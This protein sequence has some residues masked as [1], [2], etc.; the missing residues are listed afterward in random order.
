M[1]TMASDNNNLTEQQQLALQ[2]YSS[3]TDQDIETA[4][5]LLRRSQWNVEIAIAKFFDG[6]TLDPTVEAISSQGPSID[7]PR[8]LENLQ[9]TALLNSVLPSVRQPRPDPAPRIVPQLDV[10]EIRKPPFILAIFLAPFNL[11]YKSV[12]SSLSILAYL[13]PLTRFVRLRNSASYQQSLGRRPLKPRDS[14]AR[15]KREFEEEYGPNRLPFYEGGYAQA[16]DLAKAE[17]K[18]LVIVL[19]SPEHDETTKFVRDTLL[20]A[21]IQAYLSDESSNII[22]WAGDV[23]D[24][25]AYQ[26]SAAVKCS[27]FPYTAVVAHTPVISTTSMSVITALSGPMSAVNYLSKLRSCILKH[28]EQ[29]VATRASRLAQKFERTLRQEQDS[30]YERSL[31]RDKERARLKRQVEEEAAESERQRKFDEAAK[32]LL[33][34][35]RIQWRKWRATT[36]KPE[37][38]L[39]EKG[40][41]RI[42]F[43]MPEKYGAARITRRFRSEDSIEEL[44]AFIECFEFIQEG[45]TEDV[46]KPEQYDHQFE[47]QLVQSLP[48]VVYSVT[49]GSTVG[50]KVGKS[51]NIIVELFNTDDDDTDQ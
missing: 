2:T 5:P 15:L 49:D 13:S 6:E 27:E 31:A 36:I 4:I 39:D 46:S 17:L 37:P 29:L 34:E 33:A 47:F 43:R 38:G 19:F 12:L 32:A 11:L 35:K 7:R 50:E 16:L 24:T 44:Y 3:V 30:A 28:E 51:G 48:R 20:D 1:A 26:V 25:E 22:L 40:I 42:G 21:H 10:D 23:R 45:N 41:V 14:A 8:R 18:F 9:E